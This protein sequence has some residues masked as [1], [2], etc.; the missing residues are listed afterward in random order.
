MLG[1]KPWSFVG[2]H[3]NCESVTWFVENGEGYVP[4]SRYLKG[5]IYDLALALRDLDRRIAARGGI[6]HAVESP[7]G[8]AW[9]DRGRS[10]PVAHRRDTQGEGDRQAGT[11]GGGC[12]GAGNPQAGRVK[13]HTRV[14]GLL[15]I[16]V[17]PFEDKENIETDRL[18]RCATAFA[19]WDPELDRV[20][21]V[22]TCS[23]ALFKTQVMK[24]IVDYYRA[25]PAGSQSMH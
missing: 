8:A 22:P 5:S 18:E 9:I 1:S 2:V 3:P 15:Q 21:F 13:R 7:A 19:H 17:L 16:V 24:K 10:P 12:V 25:N 14:Q 6:A 20:N 4:V 23:W 11:Y